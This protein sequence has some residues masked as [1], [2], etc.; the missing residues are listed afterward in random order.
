MCVFAA[1]IA[2]V[3]AL[4][5]PEHG[6]AIGRVRYGLKVFAAFTGVGLALGW[7]TYFIPF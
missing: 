6:D 5:D 1:F 7:L 2:V 4:V 3:S